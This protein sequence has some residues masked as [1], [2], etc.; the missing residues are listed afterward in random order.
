MAQDQGIAAIGQRIHI[1]CIVTHRIAL[2]L[3]IVMMPGH[4]LRIF[5][6]IFNVFVFIKFPC[7]IAVPVHLDH[8]KVILHAILRVSLS[9]GAHHI[10]AG[11]HFVGQSVQTF[12]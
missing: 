8:I 9:G 11:E 5:S 3:K 4:P 7:D 10:T 6:R 1:G 2:T 12:P